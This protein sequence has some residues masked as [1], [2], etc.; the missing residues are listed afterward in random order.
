MPSPVRSILHFGAAG[1][2]VSVIVAWCCVFRFRNASGGLDEYAGGHADMLHAPGT[3]SAPPGV[4]APARLWPIP[5]PEKA[6]DPKYRYVLL[7]PDATVDVAL[8]YYWGCKTGYGLGGGRISTGLP[9]R[10]MAWEMRQVDLPDVFP[11]QQSWTAAA[12]PK[13]FLPISTW[14]S[15]LPLP[16]IAGRS[17]SPSVRE[18]WLR[19]P[20]RPVWLGLLGDSAL[21]GSAAWLLCRGPRTVRSAARRRRGCCEVCGY[22]VRGLNSCPECGELAGV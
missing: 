13:G 8:S 10:A 12:P 18:P 22:P 7:W 3:V 11:D 9:L 6:G 16:W 21:F 15:G 14:R 1:L 4:P 5:M 19:L 2:A 17:G 20:I